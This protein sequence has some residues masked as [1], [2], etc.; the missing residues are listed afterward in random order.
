MFVIIFHLFH[1]LPN[2]PL[3]SKSSTEEMEEMSFFHFLPPVRKKVIFSGRN[4][5]LARSHAKSDNSTYDESTDRCRIIEQSSGIDSLSTVMFHVGD[6]AYEYLLT[7]TN[8]TPGY[9]TLYNSFAY[10]SG[11]Q[12]STYDR[13]NDLDNTAEPCAAYYRG[14]WWFKHC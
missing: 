7:I 2:L 9:D 5:T 6:A 11:T 4:S 8:D 14:G 13:D 1:F 12:F 3:P 10:Q